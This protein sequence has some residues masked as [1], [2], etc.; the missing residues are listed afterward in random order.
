[1][2]DNAQIVKSW[3]QALNQAYYDSKPITSL[4][5]T[6]GNLSTEDAYQVQFRMLEDRIKQGE[7]LIGWKIGATS[8]AVQGSF[9]FPLSE[10]VFGWMTDKSDYSGLDKIS[11]SSFCNLHMEA[12]IDLVLKSPLKG[13]GV[14]NADIISATLGVMA[15]VELVGGRLRE[16]KTLSDL[17]ADNS[18][19][20][21]IILGPF[22]KPVINFDLRYESVTISKNGHHQASARGCEVM[23]NPINAVRWLANKLVQFGRELD[24]GS[25]ISTGSLTRIIPLEPGDIVN[26]SFANLGDIQFEITK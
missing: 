6:F 14:T 19:H 5:D 23:G 17:V 2:V 15:A 26:V 8:S 10:P 11:T 25:V 4:S 12:E 20:A 3:I 18:G 13:P 7:R 24:A 16:R 9:S 1:M 21:G 22:I